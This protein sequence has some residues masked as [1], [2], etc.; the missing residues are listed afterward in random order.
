MKSQ[1]LEWGRGSFWQRSSMMSSEKMEKLGGWRKSAREGRG[2]GAQGYESG[3]VSQGEFMVL[4]W[5]TE[6]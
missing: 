6:H 2:T 1:E 4:E 3:A 5:E